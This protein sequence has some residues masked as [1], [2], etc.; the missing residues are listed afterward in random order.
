M[1]ILC[2]GSA[3][4]DI[5]SWPVNISELA[6]RHQ[7]PEITFVGPGGC[8]ANQAIGL[9]ALGKSVT[10]IARLADDH[11]GCIVRD[12]LESRGVGVSGLITDSALPTGKTLVLVDR[13]GERRFIYTAGAN[14]NLQ[15]EDI[16]EV[17]VS[18]FKALH[19]P[20]IFLINHLHGRPLLHLLERAR[21]AGLM[22][23][24][25]TIWDPD[26]RWMDALK[27]YLPLLDI[28]FVSEEE[29][30]H[31]LPGLTAEQWIQTFL[32]LGV[33]MVALKRG[34]AG[35]MIGKGEDRWQVIPPKVNPLDTT[36]AGDA[37]VAGFLSAILEGVN[38]EQAAQI[39]DAFAVHSLSWLGATWKMGRWTSSES[40]FKKN[41]IR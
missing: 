13:E 4:A 22:T 27:P 31:L 20:D 39:A 21:K 10:L 36:G 3:L 19:I 37:Y 41:H 38:P 15:P 32:D 9:T 11:L 30:A 35:S 14:G 1:T 40:F 23:S 2:V 17:D 5:T 8:A 6:E 24:M 34:A 26:G 28:L 29:A 16:D 18:T 12:E 25:D 33:G 7:C